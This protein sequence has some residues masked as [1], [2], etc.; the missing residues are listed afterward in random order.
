MKAATVLVNDVDESTGAGRGSTGRAAA[1]QQAELLKGSTP[2]LLACL[3]WKAS[4]SLALAVVCTPREILSYR[5]RH[6]LQLGRGR[7]VWVWLHIL[8]VDAIDHLSCE[9]LECSSR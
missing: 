2:C 6:V 1:S 9:S 3:P 7:E 5:T 4:S 8:G